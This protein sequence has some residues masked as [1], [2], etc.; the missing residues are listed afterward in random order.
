[1][2]FKMKKF[3][4]FIA[5]LVFAWTL[6]F[7]MGKQSTPNPNLLLDEEIVLSNSWSNIDVKDDSGIKELE[8]AERDASGSSLYG[9]A[10]VNKSQNDDLKEE[11]KMY[12]E[13]I[14]SLSDLQQF[15]SSVDY[16]FDKIEE[17][18]AKIQSIDGAIEQAISIIKSQDASQETQALML[19][20]S[21][22]ND[23]N[24]FREL[25]SD[26]K[27]AESDTKDKI[28]TTLSNATYYQNE[29]AYRALLDYAEVTADPEIQQEMVAI[30]SR[31]IPTDGSSDIANQVF[32]QLN[33]YANSDDPNV[34]FSALSSLSHVNPSHAY[35]DSRVLN[36]LEFAS[37]DSER[38][39]YISLLVNFPEPTSNTKNIVSEIANSESETYEIRA[40]AFSVLERWRANSK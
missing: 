31:H 22:I 25:L 27:N 21:T 39:N 38:S 14:E 9:G 19:S 2:K 10:L 28:K 16:S 33:R 34:V 6:G 3:I 26:L 12:L 32:N 24:I 18:G 17:L 36:K 5:T 11:Q 13:D 37:D 23:E 30:L 40:L 15:I 29:A 1:M 20:I 4:S 35:L 8:L 7:Y